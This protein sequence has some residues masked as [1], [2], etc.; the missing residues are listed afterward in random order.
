MRAL[1]SRAV[2]DWKRV[3]RDEERLEYLMR[4]EACGVEEW[5]WIDLPEHLRKH[6]PTCGGRLVLAESRPLRR[7]S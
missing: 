6:Y 3:P 2:I 7:S 5:Y 4:C 1:R